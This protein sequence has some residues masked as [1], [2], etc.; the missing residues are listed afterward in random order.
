[1]GTEPILPLHLAASFRNLCQQYAVYTGGTLGIQLLQYTQLI[2]CFGGGSGYMLTANTYTAELV[3]A[4]E[5][6]SSFGRIQGA[7]M[8]GMG[9]AF[10]LGGLTT[11]LFGAPW[12]FRVTWCLLL[13]SSA[14]SLFFLPYIAPV[15]KPAGGGGKGVGRFAFLAPLRMFVPRKLENGATYYGVSLLAVGVFGGVLANSFVPTMLQLHS[16]SSCSRS[17]DRP[18]RFLDPR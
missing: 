18:V 14:M 11:D 13:L 1:M 6:T 8:L 9:A 15:A 10:S 7:A 2:T 16:V 4:E 3:S 5:R 12:C 17:R